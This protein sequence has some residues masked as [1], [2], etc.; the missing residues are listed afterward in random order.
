VSTAAQ[1]DAAREQAGDGPASIPVDALL[2]ANPFV[3]LNLQQIVS[4]FGRVLLRLG[5]RPRVVV[6]RS[7][8]LAKD[9]A[10]VLAGREVVPPA[11]SDKRWAD[12]AWRENPAYRRVQQAYL[13]VATAL[14][15]AIEEAG[16][17]TKSEARGKFATA[18]IVEGLAPSN[19]PLNP[20]VLKRAFDTGGKSLL[21]GVRHAVSD[22]RGNH[23]MPRTVDRRPFVVGESIA[24]TPGAVVHRSPVLELIQYTPTTERVHEVP[25]VYV[26]P[27]INKYY[28][29]DLAP[30]RSFV[31]NALGAGIQ[32]FAVSYANPGP[33]RRD[34]G[35]DAY[36]E[37][38]LEAIEAAREITG[39]ESVH[40]MGLCAGGM[41]AAALLGHLAAK[42]ELGKIR[43]LSLLVSMLDT[44]HDSQLAALSSRRAIESSLSKANKQGVHRGSD[45]ARLFAWLRPNDLVFNYVVNNWLLGQD[46]P[47]FDVLAWN[48]DTTNLPAGLYRDFIHLYEGNRLREP[49][50]LTVLGT[51]VD[52]AKVDV[53][54]Y[55]VAGSTDHIVPWQAAWATTQILGG[56]VE[57]VLSNSGHI[58]SLVNPLGNP[59]ASYFAGD[60]SL[61][62]ADAWVKSAQQQKGSWWQHWVEWVRPRS[63]EERPAPQALGDTAHPPLVPAPGV[64]VTQTAD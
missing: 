28:V 42:G 41:T 24:V 25:V 43:S 55:A 59:K 51:P 58:Q 48:A 26:P 20:A 31:E 64:Y 7:G 6:R 56:D 12:P 47:A 10:L 14:D 9:L 50:G 63:G 46:P 11:R 37:A 62:D 30:G 23:G 17:D 1:V 38:I 22:I 16:L 13:A 27:Q 29:L 39:S 21:T 33:E 4:A 61:R 36:V 40:L 3:G 54:A 45:M 2:A 52:L 44:A 18:I 53:D 34:W 8:A 49:F 60:G 5:L 19:T 35:L 57:F 32:F 15:R